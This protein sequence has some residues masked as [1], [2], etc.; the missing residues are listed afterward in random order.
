MA[1]YLG[2]GSYVFSFGAPTA[3]QHI[4]TPKGEKPIYTVGGIRLSDE[5]DVRRGIVISGRKKILK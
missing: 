2:S 5:K 4:E 1:D 3:V